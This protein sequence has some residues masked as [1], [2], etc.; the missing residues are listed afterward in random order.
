MLDDTHWKVD[1]RW[2]GITNVGPAYYKVGLFCSQSSGNPA[3]QNQVALK[4]VIDDVGVLAI[5][6]CLI[7]EL[8]GLLAPEVIYDLTDAEVQRVAGESQESAAERARATEKLHVLENGI[9]T[10]PIHRVSLFRDCDSS[11]TVTGMAELKRL[12][13]HNPSVLTIQEYPNECESPIATDLDTV[14]EPGWMTDAPP[15][16]APPSDDGSD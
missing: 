6:R 10:R 11:K 12:K 8:P 15:I 9:V 1:V 3:D 7:Q 5:E 13:K 2:C 14:A 4:K 16:P